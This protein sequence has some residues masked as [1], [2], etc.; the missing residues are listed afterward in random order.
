MSLFLTGW[1][2]VV[3]VVVIVIL[4]VRFV[5]RFLFADRVTRGDGDSAPEVLPSVQ[6]DEKVVIRDRLHGRGDGGLDQEV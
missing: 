1:F 5:R 3:A 6:F 2:N 4:G